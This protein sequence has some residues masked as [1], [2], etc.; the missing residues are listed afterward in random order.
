MP[1]DKLLPQIPMTLERPKKKGGPPKDTRQKVAIAVKTAMTEAFDHVG[2]VAALVRW[3]KE[4]PGQFY[5]FWV[6]M[7]P[8]DQRIDL[9][10]REVSKLS[11]EELEQRRRKLKLL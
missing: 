4:N 5:H 9:D 10:V 2:G 1:T 3:G 7:L 6:K 8:Q 11:D